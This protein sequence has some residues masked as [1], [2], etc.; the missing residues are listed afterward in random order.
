MRKLV[1]RILRAVPIAAAAAVVLLLC[2]TPRMAW[3]TPDDATSSAAPTITGIDV[4]QREGFRRLAGKRVGLLTNHTGKARDGSATID[5]LARSDRLKLIALFSPE[6]GI[7]GELDAKVPSSRDAATGLVIHSL[8]GD[9]RRPTDAMLAGL[10]TLVI[11]LQDIG[12]RFYTYMTTMAYMME[13]AAQH[14]LEV[15][16]LDRPNPINGITVE[17]PGLQSD[18]LGFTAYRPMPIRH[19]MTLGELA[20]LFDG[21][22]RDP[23]LRLGERLAVVPMEHWQRNFWFDST[24]LR[25][26]DPSPN[27]RSLVAASL[28]PGVAT[29]ESTNV[30]V[31]RGTERPFEYV[32]APWIDGV[33]LAARLNSAALPGVRAYPVRFTP[34]TSKFAG[35]SCDGVALVVTDRD[36]LQPV[37]LG[38]E[39]AAALHDQHRNEFKI[40]AMTGLFGREVVQK[41]R[42]GDTP[43]AIAD[44]WL[45]E[46]AGWRALRS[47]YL[48][49]R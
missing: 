47:R 36:A 22:Q 45:D 21:E 34:R 41:L 33:R 40:E 5:L 38:L 17:G 28:Y 20:R 26:V 42:R 37:R 13:A 48:L 44:S 16:V 2:V 14:G 12:A 7:R 24:G 9:A 31:G 3:A 43:Q 11:D 18:E 30:S 19:G 27:M 1:L 49:Y 6:H 4:L 32:G 10:D 29:I 15:V 8:Y 39:L 35:E 23:A 46:A 25:W